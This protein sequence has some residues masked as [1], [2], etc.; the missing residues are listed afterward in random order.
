[1]DINRIFGVSQQQYKFITTITGN[2]IGIAD[3][4]QKSCSGNHQ[5][6]IASIMT[7]AIV[8]L[9]KTIQINEQ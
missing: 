9:F 8:N 4:G 7:M 5:H 3:R 1:M 2:I 6:L